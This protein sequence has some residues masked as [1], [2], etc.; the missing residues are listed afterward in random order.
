MTKKFGDEDF[1]DFMDKEYNKHDPIIIIIEAIRCKMLAISDIYSKSLDA[2]M[3]LKDDDPLRE[4]LKEHI[5]KMMEHT[6]ETM[7]Q[8][9]YA[10]IEDEDD[11]EEGNGPGGV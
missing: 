2:Y 1:K 4:N 9:N 8:F 3:S 11:T 10:L 7:N 6:Q 5:L